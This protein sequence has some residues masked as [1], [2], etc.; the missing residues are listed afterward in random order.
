MQYLVF[1][2]C[3]SAKMFSFRK[4]AERGKCYVVSLSRVYVEEGLCGDVGIPSSVRGFYIWKL[5][6]MTVLMR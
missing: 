3:H 1:G 6:G 5:R 4:P 2:A